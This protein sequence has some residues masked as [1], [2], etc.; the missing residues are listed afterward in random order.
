MITIDITSRNTVFNPLSSQGQWIQHRFGQRSYPIIDLDKSV[1]DLALDKYDTI[2][3]RSIYGDPLCHPD[4][5]NIVDAISKT[6]KQCFIFSYLN[7]KD[8]NL[9]KKISNID[10]I[11]IYA[12]IDGYDSYGTTI[13]N[14]N[15]KTV[16]RNIK[17][18]N[19]KVILE[20]FMYKHN[21]IDYKKIKRLIVSQINLLPGKKLCDGPSSIIDQDGNWLYDVCAVDVFDESIYDPAL[22]K[23]L[24]SYKILIPYLRTVKGKSILENPMIIRTIKNNEIFVHDMPA[25]SLTGHVFESVEYMDIFTNALCNDWLIDANNISHVNKTLISKLSSTSEQDLYAIRVNTALLDI[26]SKGLSSFCDSNI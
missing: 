13:L 15:K 25:I 8:D 11:T 6:N 4:I 19:K 9:I 14:S 7:I 5:N 23:Y 22:V 18:L 10:N 17:M 1:I 21:L 24:T 12:I 16:F 20:F 26:T 3:F 2:F